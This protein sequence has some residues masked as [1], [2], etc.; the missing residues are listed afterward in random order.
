[1]FSI[2]V[3]VLE[4]EILSSFSLV[5][6]DVPIL[7]VSFVSAW[8]ILPLDWQLLGGHTLRLSV[9]EQPFPEENHQKYIMIQSIHHFYRLPGS[10]DANC[11]TLTC[12]VVTRLYQKC[13]SRKATNCHMNL[14]RL[15]KNY[16]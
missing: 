2:F 3:F 1:M 4:T 8:R 7:F 16:E 6:A 5:V 10:F 9:L 15:K 13:M 14:H 11:N 12:F